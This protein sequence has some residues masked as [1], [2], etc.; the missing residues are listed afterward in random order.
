MA[1]PRE[2]SQEVPCT[3]YVKLLPSDLSSLFFLS[4]EAA[5]SYQCLSPYEPFN[6]LYGEYSM[7]DL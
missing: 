6:A 4:P 7:K 3:L 1:K 2:W 5:F